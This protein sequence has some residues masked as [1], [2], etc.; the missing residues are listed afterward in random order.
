MAREKHGLGQRISLRLTAEQQKQVK[1]ATGKQAR[2]LE[3]TA[4]ELEDRIAPSSANIIRK[5]GGD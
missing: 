1:Q 4:E 5:S 3:L 2:A